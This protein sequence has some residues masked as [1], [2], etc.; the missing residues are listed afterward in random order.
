MILLRQ[1]IKCLNAILK[2]QK[3]Y[4]Y[5]LEVF[6]SKMCLKMMLKSSRKKTWLLKL[7]KSQEDQIS[8]FKEPRHDQYILWNTFCFSHRRAIIGHQNSTFSPLSSLSFH[9]QPSLGVN[10]PQCPTEH[11][12]LY[13]KHI[14]PGFSFL[15]F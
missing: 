5:I 4:Q 9:L 7:V 3:N 10:S 13:V 15:L 2:R 14:T 6:L 8:L 12:F 1:K 11:S